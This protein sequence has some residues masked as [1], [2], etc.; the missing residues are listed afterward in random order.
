MPNPHY[1]IFDA[2]R[3]CIELATRAIEEV[4]ALA[5]RPPVQG[6]PGR[7]GFSLE[8]LAFEY[9]G[10]RRVTLR[11][12]CGDIKKELEL[13]LPI[14]IYRGVYKEGERYERGDSVS[15]GGSTFVAHEDTS[16]KPETSKA[17]QLSVKR[18]RDGRD[19]VV[20]N[21]PTPGPIKV[22]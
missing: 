4:R 21:I 5:K 6:P 12:E 3:I 11:F 20:R 13:V 14:P 18:G 22:G 15:F 17:W 1:N 7:D 8:D 9:D 10:E 16:D 19:G 2:V